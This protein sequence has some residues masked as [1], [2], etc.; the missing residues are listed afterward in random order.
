MHAMY[1]KII[2]SVITVLVMLNTGCQYSENNHYANNSFIKSIVL[3]DGTLDSNMLRRYDIPPREGI[4]LDPHGFAQYEVDHTIVKKQLRMNTS[5]GNILIVWHPCV[6]LPDRME[7]WDD[8]FTRLMLEN[9]PILYSQGPA[10]IW[11]KDGL[12]Q[13]VNRSHSWIL[14]DMGEKHGIYIFEYSDYADLGGPIEIF[15]KQLEKK[16]PFDLIG[17][18]WLDSE[19]LGKKYIAGIR[20]DDGIDELAF[21]EVDSTGKRKKVVKLPLDGTEQVEYLEGPLARK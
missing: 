8:R 15:I 13:Y 14:V 18:V 5:R 12:L 6:T 20:K 3:A 2:F 16:E 4:E 21:F 1:N 9:I 19:V 17:V 7:V 11:S 10:T